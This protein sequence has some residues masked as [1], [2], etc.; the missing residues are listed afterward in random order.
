MNEEELINF[1]KENLKLEI[2]YTGYNSNYDDT[3]KISISL[4]DEELCSTSFRI[5][6]YNEF[7]CN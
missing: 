7:N 4:K 1:L 2:K 6:D 3:Y 5:N